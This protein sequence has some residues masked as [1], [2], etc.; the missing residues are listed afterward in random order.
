MPELTDPRLIAL[1][2]VL[3]SE[4]LSARIAEAERQAEL[5]EREFDKLRAGDKTRSQAPGYPARLA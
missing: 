3:S 4:F 1:Q 5:V 2:G